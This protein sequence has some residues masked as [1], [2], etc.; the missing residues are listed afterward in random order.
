[1]EM[2]EYYEIV[3][4]TAATQDYADWILDVIDTKKCISHRLYR[5]HALTKGSHFLKVMSFFIFI[6]TFKKDLSKL[7]RDLKKIIII[8]NLA[9]NFELQ[10]ENGIFIQSWYGDPEDRALFEL[11]PLLKG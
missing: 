7:G 8:D 1:M 6:F 2:K 10:P 3:V 11:A 5:D 4:F 9:E